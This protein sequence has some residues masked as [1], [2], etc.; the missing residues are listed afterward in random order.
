MNDPIF[1]KLGTNITQLEATQTQQFLFP[2]TTQTMVD[3][4][5]GEVREMVH[6]TVTGFRNTQM[7]LQD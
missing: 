5:I 6:G 7:C 3:V 2:M 1:T 4:R